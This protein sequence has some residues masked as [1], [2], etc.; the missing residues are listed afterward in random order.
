MKNIMKL[1]TI[2]Q[3]LIVPKNRSDNKA[4]YKFRSLDDITEKL[5]PLLKETNTVLLFGDEIIS[6][7]GRFYVHSIAVLYDAESGEEIARAGAMAREPQTEPGKGES[8][9]TGSASSYARKYA[10]CA[11]F[12]IDNGEKDPDEGQGESVSRLFDML[13]AAGVVPDTLEKAVRCITGGK[14]GADKIKDV[15]A[16][17]FLRPENWKRAVDNLACAGIIA[18]ENE[19]NRN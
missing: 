10:A 19:N 7:D 2:Q 9:I 8:Q 15:T 5:K 4:R 14:V 3:Q 17:Y 11:L 1:F 12:A 18:N 6:K 13:F 16:D